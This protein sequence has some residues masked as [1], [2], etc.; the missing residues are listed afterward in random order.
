MTTTLGHNPSYVWQS[1]LKA[2]FILRGGSRWCIGNG[3]SIPIVNEPWLLKGNQIDNDI[4]GVHLVR[5]FVVSSLINQDSKS[6]NYDV[7]QQVFSP[8]ISTAILTTPLFEQVE[9]DTLIWKGENNGVYSAKSAY[10]ICVEELMDTSHFRRSG[11][12]YRIWRLKV[13]PKVKHLI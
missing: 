1:I 12:W 6:W 5:D 2:R 3:N 7:F 13:P 10:R 4:E 8:Y 11:Y 9:E